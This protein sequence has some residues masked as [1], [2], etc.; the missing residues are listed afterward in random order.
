[1]Q[2]YDPDRQQKLKD[3]KIIKT[4]LLTNCTSREMDKLL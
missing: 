1:M 4:E 2:L 3:K